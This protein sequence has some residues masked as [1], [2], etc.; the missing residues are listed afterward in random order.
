MASG[1]RGDDEDD[2]EDASDIF[3]VR[4]EAGSSDTLTPDEQGVDTSRSGRLTVIAFP[5]DDRRERTPPRVMN[6]RRGRESDQ[7]R[8]L[9]LRDP[10]PWSPSSEYHSAPLMTLPNPKDSRG[11]RQEC[12]PA[13]N[14]SD[15]PSKSRD[16][17]FAMKP[18]RF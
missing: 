4:S 18:P 9:E 8:S 10:G 11:S 13:R 1:G 17:K 16:S 2:W 6:Q 7:D 15:G 5:K 14:R 12:P 3:E